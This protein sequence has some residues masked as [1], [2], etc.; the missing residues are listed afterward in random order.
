MLVHNHKSLCT[1]WQLPEDAGCVTILLRTK[2]I[3]WESPD[4]AISCCVCCGE[5]SS[6]NYVRVYFPEWVCHLSSMHLCPTLSADQRLHG[7]G[8]V[9]AGFPH[10]QKSHSTSSLFASSHSSH[11]LQTMKGTNLSIVHTYPCI[12][13]RVCMNYAEVSAFHILNH[14]A[15]NEKKKGNGRG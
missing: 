10:Y 11:T 7:G 13:A 2:C 5:S 8:L 12:N 4:L 14:H 9:G 6:Q 3:F 15:D 1:I